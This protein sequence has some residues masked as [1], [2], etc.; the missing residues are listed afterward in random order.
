MIAPIWLA[1]PPEVHSALLSSG[2]GAGPL[3]AA[4]SAWAQLAA[5]Y[6]AAAEELT[7][8]LAAVHA[9]AWQGPTAA[10][11]LAAHGPYLAWLAESAA[12][13][14]VAAA[15]HQTAAGAHSAALA[16]MP[17]LAEL[18]ANHALH[19]ALVATNFFGINTIPIA[20][21]EADY[22]RM[23]VQAAET[24]AGYQVVAQ[25]ALATVAPTI[26]AP[27]I[28]APGAEAAAAATAG[29]DGA[30]AGRSGEAG[31]HL[32]AADTTA[33]SQA[34]TGWEQQIKDLLTNINMGVLDPVAKQLW[35]LLGVDGYPLPAYETATQFAQ[36]FGMI[37]GMSP[38]LAGALGWSAYHTLMLI[39]P[40]GQIAVQLAI[41][42]L[43]GAA[44]L[45]AG[46]MVGSAG[47][48]G[49]AGAAGLSGLAGI[50]APAELPVAVGGVAP[51]GVAGGPAPSAMTSAGSASAGTAPAGAPAPGA[52]A[53][54][55][56]PG[57]GGPGA[58]FGPT[59]A[60]GT[61]A[62]M[63]DPLFVATASALS[64]QRSAGSR[65]AARRSAAEGAETDAPN[66]AQAGA[67]LRSRMRHR[68]R[69]P[70]VATERGYRYEFLDAESLADP[71]PPEP[72]G[73]AAS[74]RSAGAF[75]FAGVAATDRASSAVGLITVDDEDDIRVPML[76]GSWRG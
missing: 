23:W 6:T 22:V 71:A 56:G 75:G 70:G 15:A 73:V 9:G 44:P 40:M 29:T 67:A 30:G 62:P 66:P 4:G 2:P 25:T 64:A 58:G 20:V 54:A 46:A 63:S 35:K 55:P 28:V 7:A 17:T 38:V 27:P 48:A 3:V 19:A 47:V 69:R 74:T 13:S 39:W 32:R 41:P 12:K 65:R 5:E 11:Y 53:T 33:D 76:P 51:A 60:E 1:S 16:T 37:P 8:D 31:A 18:A 14:S 50:G 59:A 21:N 72:A 57:G 49:M 45:L 43:V 61:G 24:M 36:L 42:V 26:P 34:A 10:R 52:A 68:R